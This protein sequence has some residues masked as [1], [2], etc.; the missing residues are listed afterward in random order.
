MHTAPSLAKS[1]LIS[2]YSSKKCLAKISVASLLHK[3]IYNDFYCWWVDDVSFQSPLVSPCT[4]LGRS[5]LSIV[6]TSL[7]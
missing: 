4:P 2:S 1:P 6:Q 3:M 7:V 5:T